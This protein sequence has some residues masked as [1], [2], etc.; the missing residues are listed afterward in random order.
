M[1]RANF[2][3]GS[4]GCGIRHQTA[5][6]PESHVIAF[7]KSGPN[8]AFPNCV[9]PGLAQACTYR[10]LAVPL[11]AH[12]M[13]RSVNGNLRQGRRMVPAQSLPESGFSCAQIWG[14]SVGFH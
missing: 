12:T 3:G 13:I 9:D 6:P 7:V 4:S 14:T 11:S 1:T 2:L 8:G 10:A 5:E